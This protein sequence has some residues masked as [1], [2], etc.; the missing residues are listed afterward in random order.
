MCYHYLIVMKDIFTIFV[1]NILHE[2]I[3]K[4]KGKIHIDDK[5][6]SYVFH[7]QGEYQKDKFAL[8]C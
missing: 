8:L 5:Q 3:E 6:N 4:P 1:K 2:P 7:T